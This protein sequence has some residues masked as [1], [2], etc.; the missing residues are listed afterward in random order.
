MNDT[1]N[2]IEGEFQRVTVGPNDV[3]VIT[4]PQTL[5]QAA[6]VSTKAQSR[7]LFPDNKIL[8]IDNGGKIGVMAPEDQE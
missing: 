1:I 5:S 8:I 6:I 7:G 2:L 4:F 3:I